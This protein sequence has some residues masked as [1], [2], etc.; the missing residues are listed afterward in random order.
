M[1]EFSY[2]ALSESGAVTRGSMPAESEQELEERLR[3][4]G[5]YLITARLAGSSEEGAG[6]GAGSRSVT[7]GKID[8]REM[9]GFTEYVASSVEAGIPILSTLDDATER[10]SSKRMKRIAAEIQASMSDEGK[11]LSE[12][13]REHP[14]AFDALY[15]STVAAGEA[16]GHLDY[17]LNQL[18]EY[19]DW[20]Q[21][22]RSQLRQATVYPAIVLVAMAVLITILVGFVFPRL[23]PVLSNFDVDLPWPTLLIMSVADFMEAYW[24]HLLGGFIGLVVGLALIRRTGRGRRVLDAIALRVPVFGPLVHQINMARFVTYLAL[25][26]RT[27]V[28][29]LHGLE[30]VE[31][32]M[33]N[34][35]VADAVR[36]ARLDVAQGETLATAFGASGLFPAVV[37]RSIALGERTGSLDQA[38]GRA[39]AYYDREVPA[40]VK[41]MLTGLQPLLVVVMG[42]LI[43]IIALSIFLPILTIYQSLGR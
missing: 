36:Q 15:V 19:L 3:S 43:V 18:V 20:Q 29:L 25:F 27:G 6:G 4:Q 1:P 2:E 37:V 30:M 22:I 14:K 42:G 12:A 5:S 23:F 8:R 40:A 32:M 17:A 26:Y 10:M 16:T 34:Q 41:R 21:E 39:K 24:L 33:D 28:E 11:S 9:L 7:D 31:E 35:V 38:L 13:L